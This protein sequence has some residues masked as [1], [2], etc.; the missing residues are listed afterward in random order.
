MKIGF[1]QEL[2]WRGLI[3]DVT[4]YTKSNLDQSDMFAGYIGFD[5]TAPSLHVGN[6]CAI[7]LLKHL[8]LSGHKPIILV[9]GFTGGIGDPAGK[10]NERKVLTDEVV[11]KNIE[12]LRKQFAKFLD[13]SCCPNSAEIVNN[14]EWLRKLP[15]KDFFRDLGK[16]FSVNYMMAKDSVKTRLDN[17]ISFTEFAYQLLQAYDFYWLF[18]NKNCKLQMGGSDQWGNITGGI[19]FIKRKDK[20]DCFALTTPL[21]LKSDGGKFGKSEEGN[22]WLDPNLTS[23]YKFYQFWLNVEDSHI[24]KL[25]RV[26]T[27][28]SKDEIENMEADYKDNPNNLKRILAEYMTTLVHSKDIF[29]KVEKASRL[30]FSNSTIEDFQQTDE[31]ILQD[32]VQGIPQYEFTNEE[33]E[34][35]NIY[36]LIQKI[37]K[38]TTSEARRLI[39]NNGISINKNKISH[40][41]QSIA[42]FPLL[43][44]KYLV[45]QK[46]KTYGLAKFMNI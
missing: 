26:F 46:G 29:H 12:S 21:L 1:L 15:L 38:I 23:P 42:E 14:D 10:A 35:S 25:L 40:E 34:T 22:I 16:C 28:Y 27:L 41:Q 3:K 18:H 36:Y 33:Y 32:I 4:E 39:K 11:N 43:K 37:F 24:G 7:N 20:K 13:F 30:F 45:I 6:L 19:D 5:P 2:G 8:Q 31:N 17:G 9:G 44:D